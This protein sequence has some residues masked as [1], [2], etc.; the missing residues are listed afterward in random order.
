[1][2]GGRRAVGAVPRGWELGGVGEEA[3]DG[4]GEG[5]GGRPWKVVERCISGERSPEKMAR[6]ESRLRNSHSEHD[7]TFKVSANRWMS[8]DIQRSA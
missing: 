3:V 6:V 8:K 2:G 4:K 1:M 7:R 5:R